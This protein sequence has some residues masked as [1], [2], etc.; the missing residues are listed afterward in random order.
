M[1][2]HSVANDVTAA[3]TLN[4]YI[5]DTL[6]LKGTKYNCYEGT[7]GACIVVAKITHPVTTKQETF[8]INSVRHE[9]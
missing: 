8:S 6:Q 3:T 2:L 7:C 1:L 9:F 5:R 4:A